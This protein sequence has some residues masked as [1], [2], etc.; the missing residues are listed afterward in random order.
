M[1]PHKV[2][3]ISQFVASSG[4]MKECLDEGASIYKLLPGEAN[5]GFL[6]LLNAEKDK[7]ATEITPERQSVAAAVQATA[8]LKLAS[9]DSTAW[10]LS[11]KPECATMFSMVRC[12]RNLIVNTSKVAQAWTCIEMVKSPLFADGF[13]GQVL[14]LKTALQDA[15]SYEPAAPDAVATLESKSSASE[16]VVV[17]VGDVEQQSATEDREIAA[18][19][20]PSVNSFGPLVRECHAVYAALQAAMKCKLKAHLE[21]QTIQCEEY[22]EAN[23]KDWMG[24]SDVAHRSIPAIKRHMLQAGMDVDKRKTVKALPGQLDVLKERIGAVAASKDFVVGIEPLLQKAEQTEHNGRIYT[25]MVGL[26][27]N[28]VVKRGKKI[29]DETIKADLKKCVRGLH[30]L[31]IWTRTHPDRPEWSEDGKETISKVPHL[32]ESRDPR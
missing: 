16:P 25:A 11:Q 32:I 21:Q 27:T 26:L 2:T 20:L 9:P 10:V 5:T 29:P 13:G 30:T 14:K 7:S 3:G 19:L 22:W 6:A 8:G 12:M 17:E 31:R 18:L 24:C 15:T 28:L 23:F 1:A 4:P